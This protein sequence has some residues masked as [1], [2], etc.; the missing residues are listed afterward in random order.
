MD[1]YVKGQKV[2]LTPSEFKAQGGEGAVYVKGQTAY[3][4]Y[5]DPAKMIPSAKIGELSAL[6]LPDIIR[7]QDVL[8]DNRRAPVGYTMRSVPDAVVLCQTFPRAFRERMGVTPDAMLHLVRALQEGVAHVHAQGIL[9]VDLNEMNFLIDPQ[10]RHVFFIDVD[11]YQTPHFPATALM[12]SVRDRHATAWNAGTDWFSFAVVSFQMFVGI[13]PYK[14][15]HPALK[16]LEERMQANVSALHPAVSIPAACLPFDVIPRVYRDWYRAVLDQGQRLPPPSGVLETIALPTRAHPA[17]GKRA[18]PNPAA[19]GM[20]RKH[21]VRL[22]ERGRDDG[23]C[24]FAWPPLRR[25]RAGRSNRPDAVGK[26]CRRRHS[27]QRTGAAV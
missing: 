16:T 4:V 11:S 27:G 22:G 19:A 18:V 15:K 9:I 13:H 5:A 3:K 17:D 8:L 1:V 7:P 23:G 24:L 12:E 14:G 10:F 2:R 6:T 20:R 25:G 21:C 26:S